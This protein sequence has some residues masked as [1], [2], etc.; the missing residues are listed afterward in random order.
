MSFI[1]IDSLQFGPFTD[2][3]NVDFIIPE[4]NYDFTQSYINI[5]TEINDVV[6]INF[7]EVYL[8]N[9]VNATQSMFSSSLVENVSFSTEL[10]KNIENIRKVNVL[11]QNLKEYTLSIADKQSLE[12]KDIYGNVES[13]SYY[14]SSIC[15]RLNRQGSNPSVNVESPIRVDLKDILLG[16]GNMKSMPLD[17]LGQGKLHIE[18]QTTLLKPYYFYGGDYQTVSCEALSV[19]DTTLIFK[20]A[21]NPNLYNFIEPPL[22]VGMIINIL[23]A[24]TAGSLITSITSMTWDVTEVA[25]VV[26]IKDKVA[27]AVPPSAVQPITIGSGG[28][29]VS[30]NKVE[31][32]L[33]KL[34][35]PSN[36]EQITYKTFTTEEAPGFSAGN[37]Q[38]MF[39]L[40]PN[41][42]NL[43]IMSPGTSRDSI[44]SGK[45]YTSYRF[46]LDNQ[47][48]ITRDVDISNSSPLHY[49]RLKNTLFNAG[50][51]IINLQELNYRPVMTAEG[52]V[53]NTDTPIQTIMTPLPLT[54]NEKQFQL[55]LVAASNVPR[56]ILYKQIVKTI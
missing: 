55:N 41:C 12:T 49:D 7:R 52:G 29:S 34:N 13:R 48:L 26:G 37:F 1:K 38:Q 15:R 39:Y 40:E 21:N 23:G 9:S 3:R 18:L 27:T 24:G 28:L 8:T 11:T 5:M 51:N 35:K 25:W 33:K 32:V 47:D 36:K 42:V 46:R 20:Q 44:L 50:Y 4:G 22:Y 10:Y 17:R 14:F 6:P 19:N 54:E 30:Y 56:L 31:L 2:N 45:Y 53:A 16:V 43:M